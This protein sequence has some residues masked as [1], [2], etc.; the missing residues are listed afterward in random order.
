MSSR[1]DTTLIVDPDEFRNKFEREAFLLK[2][3]IRTP[4]L[5]STTALVDAARRLPES[6]LDLKAGDVPK[7]LPHG[8][9]PD[10]TLGIEE[11]ITADKQDVWA[12][13]KQICRLP[14]Y[15]ALVDSLLDSV[16]QMTEESFPGMFARQGFIFVSSPHSV[17]PY[18]MDPEHNFLL[19]IQG[20]KT[21]TV[22]DPNDPRIVCEEDVERNYTQGHR[23]LS[24]SSEVE[25]FAT[26]VELTPGNA[27]HI[28]I[29]MPH[30]VTTGA[31]TSVSMSITFNTPRAERR[32]RVYK[33]NNLIRRV[34]LTPKPFG[35]AKY[36]DSFKAAMGGVY[37]NARAIGRGA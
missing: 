34:G 19:Q 31:E 2:Y 36:L 30:Y 10:R 35:R 29:S 17:V 33:V 28:P 32:A 5:F 26:H 23:R 13:L 18:H 12:G 4:E 8:R 3:Q 9:R 22:F 6:M 24:L 37:L 11:A 16:D 15:R 1:N 20:T 7:S 27:L 25:Q 21:V 14:E